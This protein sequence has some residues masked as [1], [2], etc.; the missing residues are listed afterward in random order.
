M[1]PAD[2]ENRF[3]FHAAATQDKRDAHTSVRQQCRLLADELNE[4]LPDSREKSVAI[5][6][7]EEV[8][9]WANAAIAR[10]GSEAN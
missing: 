3:A 7:L 4:L 1:Q 10:A 5:T 9:F 8:M 2:I 6:K